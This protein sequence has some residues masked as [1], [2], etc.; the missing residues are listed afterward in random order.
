MRM[1][2]NIMTGVSLVT[3]I[4]SACMVDSQTMI[5]A[6][7]CAGSVAVMAAACVIKERIYGSYKN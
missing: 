6:Y 1:L 2:L 5:P 7:I 4:L 3:T